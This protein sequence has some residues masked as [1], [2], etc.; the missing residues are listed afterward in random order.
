MTHYVHG[1]AEAVLRSHRTR[2]AQDSAAYLVPHLRPGQRVLDVGCGPGTITADLA[3]R[4]A[5]GTVLAIDPARAVVE[6]AAAHCLQRGLTN[7]EVTVGDV[8]ALDPA[9]GRFDVVHAHQVLQHL[10]DPVEALRRM[11]GL[12]APG[13]V[14]AV[15]DADYAAMTWY[16]NPPEL[17]EWRALY[18]HLATA[19]GGQPDAGRRLLAWARAAGFSR[20]TPSASTWC[21]ATDESR[22]QWGGMWADRIVDSDLARQALAS[23]AAQEQD[24]QRIRAAWHRWAADGDGWFTI[25]HGELLCRND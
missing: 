5:P 23:G 14:V 2:T 24:L 9:D 1:H 3:E 8:Y 16:P 18:R 17:E 19:S 6:Q 10:P 20:I 4:V 25:T 22:A 12:A 21:F 13:G 11:R 15:R 7:V